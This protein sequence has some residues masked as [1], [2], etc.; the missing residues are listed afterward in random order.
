MGGLLLEFEFESPLFLSHR[1]I[2]F[3][4]LRLVAGAGD[5]S[6]THAHTHTLV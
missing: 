1:T 4:L 5:E 3:L 6:N 2:P